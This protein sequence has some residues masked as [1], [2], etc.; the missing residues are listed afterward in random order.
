MDSISSKTSSRLPSLISF[1]SRTGASSGAKGS[2]KTTAAITNGPAHA[3]RPASSTPAIG[4]I[5]D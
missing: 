3:P 5:P 1:E 4:E 2:F